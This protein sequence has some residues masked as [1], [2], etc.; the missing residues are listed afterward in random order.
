MKLINTFLLMALVLTSCQKEAF[1]EERGQQQN[2]DVA[3]SVD[4]S[5]EEIFEDVS[6]QSPRPSLDNSTQGIYHGIFGTYDLSAHGEIIINVG[7]DG[8]YAAALHLV[9][10]EK[11]LFEATNRLVSDLK[12]ASDRGSFTLDVSD[13]ENPVASLVQLDDTEGYV[14]VYKEKSSRRLSIA[15]GRYIDRGDAS[16][17]GNW[18]LI[19]FGIPEFNFPGALRVQEVILSNGMSLY[20]DTTPNILEPFDGCFGLSVN[21]PYMA[22]LSQNLR[23]LEGKLQ[24]SFINGTRC[25]WSLAVT[26]NNFDFEYLDTRCEPT[27]TAGSWAWNGREG[28]IEIQALRYH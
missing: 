10:G 28:F 8:N 4:A 19:S 24:T 16:F 27:T 20:Y 2:G 15:L 25:R 3:V 14:V 13:I 9:T 21:G 22:E 17:K 23:I 26:Q 5:E 7:N 11:L 6:N 1:L 18:D 12:F